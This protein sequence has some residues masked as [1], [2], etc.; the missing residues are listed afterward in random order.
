[1]QVDIEGSVGRAETFGW[2]TLLQVPRAPKHEKAA[3]LKSA[4][5]QLRVPLTF[6]L[7]PEGQTWHLSEFYTI[8]TNSSL[9]QILNE[10]RRY[11]LDEV[12]G[13]DRRFYMIPESMH[14]KRAFCVTTGLSL[15]NTYLVAPPPYHFFSP[16]PTPTD[17]EEWENDPW[18][19]IFGHL[20][21]LPS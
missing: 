2:Q 19:F 14:W 20:D 9:V 12:I 11:Q 16:N 8:D 5:A 10:L 17:L 21:Q 1:V 13:E 15:K 3:L 18:L 4:A 6:M 7:N